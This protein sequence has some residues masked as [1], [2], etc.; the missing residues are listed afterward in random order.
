[1]MTT[2]MLAA[3]FAGCLGGDDDDEEWTL[4][5]ASDVDSVIVS[6]QVGTAF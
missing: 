1:M 5:V 4:S 3:A 6:T 2:S